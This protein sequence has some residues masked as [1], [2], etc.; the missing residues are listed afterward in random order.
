MT[1]AS[2]DQNH[3]GQYNTIMT[4]KQNTANGHFHQNKALAQLEMPAL[5]YPF[6]LTVNPCDANMAITLNAISWT[7]TLGDPTLT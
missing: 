2:T 5:T 4:V 1:L 7:Y 3:I 6:V